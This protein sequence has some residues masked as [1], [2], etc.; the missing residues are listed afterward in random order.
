MSPSFSGCQAEQGVEIKALPV[1][2][3]AVFRHDHTCRSP[4][5]LLSPGTFWYPGHQHKSLI[6][7]S[8]TSQA[9]N[10]TQDILQS[11]FFVIKPFLH[12]GTTGQ[13]L[14]SN[15][16]QG[17]LVGPC[18]DPH[19]EHFGRALKA[20]LSP[21]QTPSQCPSQSS[22]GWAGSHLLLLTTLQVPPLLDGLAQ[23]HG[24]H[25]HLHLTDDVVL[26][27]S[28]KVVDGHHQSLPTQ[29]LVGH[30]HKGTT[31]RL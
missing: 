24:V 10:S 9:Q 3:T 17:T 27:E 13:I 4:Q 30:L 2:W 8:R 1:P 31:A 25:G 23:V 18:R 28:I 29:L 26:G 19:P 11:S 22:G 7:G 20:E 5:A 6:T 12:R 15:D 16:C 21:C 14:P